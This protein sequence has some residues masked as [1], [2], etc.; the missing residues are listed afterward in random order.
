MTYVINNGVTTSPV[1]TPSIGSIENNN[2]SGDN[3]A[4]YDLPNIV[5]PVTISA[6]EQLINV[7]GG[8]TNVRDVAFTLIDIVIIKIWH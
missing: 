8:C 6:E 1:N 4:N 5:N 3:S 2:L 7:F